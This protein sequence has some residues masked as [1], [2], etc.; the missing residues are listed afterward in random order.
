MV[1]GAAPFEAVVD[2]VAAAGIAGRVNAAV[3]GSPAG[4]PAGEGFWRRLH[5]LIID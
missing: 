5:R 3:H 4:P 2:G 1:Q